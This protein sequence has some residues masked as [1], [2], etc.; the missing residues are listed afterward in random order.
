AA[1]FAGSPKSVKG[2]FLN[3]E[4][5][6]LSSWFMGKPFLTLKNSG[7]GYSIED[8]GPLWGHYGALYGNPDTV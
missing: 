5:I 7:L 4:A 8:L 6:C 2:S 3:S 1:A